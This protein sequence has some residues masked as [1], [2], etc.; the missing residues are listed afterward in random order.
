MSITAIKGQRGQ[1]QAL[2]TCEDCGGEVTISAR[3][4][5]GRGGQG[6]PVMVLHSEASVIE[7]LKKA[8]WSYVKNR[9]RCDKCTAKRAKTEDSIMADVKTNEAAKHAAPRQPDRDQKRLI[10]LAL[11][12]AYDA[13]SQRYKGHATDRSVADD[14][15]EG[16]MPGW[17]SALREEFFGPTG[18]E[19]AES[20]RV[21]IES[22]R[23]DTAA[24]IAALTARLDALYRSEDKRVRA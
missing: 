2:C 9:L 8:G 19:E 7:S 10:I 24:R 6:R 16:V 4:G 14:L 18:N 12:D 17:V 1:E 3:H 5:S 15:G 23:A 22:L 21:E 13:K 20:I 11:E